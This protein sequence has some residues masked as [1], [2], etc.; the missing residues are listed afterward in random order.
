MSTP[1]APASVVDFFNRRA[2]DYDRE[3][4]HQTPGGFALRVRREKVFSLFDQPGG[5]VLDVGCGPGVMAKGLIDRGCEFW[6]ADPSLKM[7]EIGRSRFANDDRI[8]FVAEGTA[9]LS[10]PDNS[11]DAVLCIGVIDALDSGGDAVREMIRVLK[12]EGTLILTF[13]SLLSPYAWWKNY[14]LYPAAARWHSFRAKLGDR[15]MEPRRM[16]H[17]KVRKLYTR[18]EAFR[19]LSDRGACV[20]AVT[21]YYYNLFLS[22]LDEM[23][24]RVALRATERLESAGWP[25]WIAAGFIVRARK[26]PGATCRT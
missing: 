17:G 18:A 5:K 26:K 12:P 6:G 24:P 25:E 23:M 9:R 2:H 16:R 19:L 20:E 21:G 13:T 8:H 22:P 11:F 10:F 1:Q 7:I 3:Y 15:R 14:V 4:T